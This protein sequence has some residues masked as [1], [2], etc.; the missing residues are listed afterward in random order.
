V[1][2]LFFCLPLSYTQASD[3]TVYEEPPTA[4]EI[5]EVFG[6][7][8]PKTRG[9]KTRSLSFETAAA[10]PGP[11]R[12]S[13]RVKRPSISTVLNK[14]GNSKKQKASV[15]FPLAFSSN[16]AELSLQAKQT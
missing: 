4:N 3:V 15:A 16:S 1:T 14:T 7:S 12:L 8:V 11:V 6:E 5:L 9:I 13:S 2:T 10:V